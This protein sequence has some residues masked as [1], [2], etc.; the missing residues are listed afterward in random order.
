VGFGFKHFIKFICVPHKPEFLVNFFNKILD[1]FSFF[2]I[3]NLTSFFF[4][5]IHQ[6]F[7]IT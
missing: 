3:V 6:I 1:F 5:A 7:N 4:R 2:T